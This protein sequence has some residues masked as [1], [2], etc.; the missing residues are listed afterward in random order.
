MK[1]ILYAVIAVLIVCIG[2]L[3]YQIQDLKKMVQGD[4]KVTNVTSGESK[5]PV[6]NASTDKLPDARIAY[7][8][9]DTLNEK[10]LFISDYVKILKNRRLSLESQ[11][12][13]MSQKFQENYESAQQSAQAGILPPAEMESKKRELEQQQREIENKQIQMDNL[14]LEM[15]E[16]NDELQNNVKA[17]LADYNQGKYDY[18]MAYTNTVPTILLANPKLEIT[19]QVL[20]ALNTQYKNAKNNQKK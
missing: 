16:K 17:F 11:L 7:I 12:Q 19:N 15:Q 4:V 6:V 1:N 5:T 18:I 8:N 20:D 13:S 9:I 3:F 2:I 10:Y 14:A